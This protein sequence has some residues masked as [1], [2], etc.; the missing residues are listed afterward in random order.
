[1]PQE[2]IIGSLLFNIYIN[3]L[4]NLDIEDRILA[5]MNDTVI[6]FTG[7]TWEEAGTSLIGNCSD[8]EKALFRLS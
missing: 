3:A 7:N 1:M 2:T 6:I 5:Y 4:C 8:Q